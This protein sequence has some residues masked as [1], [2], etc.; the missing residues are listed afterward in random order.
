M[1]PNEMQF[2]NDLFRSSASLVEKLDD[3]IVMN[4]DSSNMNP[5]I[6]VWYMFGL[7]HNE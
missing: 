1:L 6:L 5:K 2:M 4:I 3:I 7:M